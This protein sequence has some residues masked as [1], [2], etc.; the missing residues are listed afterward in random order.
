MHM[1]GLNN[2]RVTPA[3][4][5]L[6]AQIDEF[7]GYWNGL[8][9]Y[10]TGLNLLGDVAHHG[11]DL[12]AVLE[13]LQNKA[14]STDMICALHKAFQHSDPLAGNIRSSEYALEFSRNTDQIGSLATADADDILPLL[15]K[16]VEWVNGAITSDQYHPLLIIAIFS[17]IFL[18]IAPFS[19]GNIKL[20]KFLIIL[21]MLKA[22]YRYAVF[23]S[24]DDLFDEASAEVHNALSQQQQSIE[25]GAPSWDIWLDCFGQLLTQHMRA[26]KSQI[27]REDSPADTMS[28]MPSLSI[29]I[30]DILHQHKRAT[31]KLLI[32]ETK[33]RRSTIKLRMQE[34]VE[35]NLVKRHGAGRGVWYSLI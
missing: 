31:M 30:L 8:D 6:F 21:L 9:D 16:L 22:D 18:Q 15:N 24:L 10:T 1:I 7:K 2:L 25:I 27:Q 12:K 4:F 33:G 14:L 34:L 35:Q 23:S 19:S 32:H 28:E 29:A 3:L 13:P 11:Q 20:A 26:L 5:R 17:A